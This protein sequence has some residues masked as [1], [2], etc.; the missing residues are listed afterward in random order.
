M[1]SDLRCPRCR[2]TL[3]A[4]APHGLC[5]ACLMEA[6][7]AAPT[8]LAVAVDGMPGSGFYTWARQLGRLRSDRPEDELPFWVEEKEAVYET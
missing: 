1:T 6:G 4:D 7:L 8:A 3:A 2:G 5:P